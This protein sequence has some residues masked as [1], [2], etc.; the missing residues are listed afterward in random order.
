MK[1][2]EKTKQQLISELEE[3]Q[4][5]IAELEKTGWAL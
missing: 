4:Q 3:L 2:N 1:D 5:R